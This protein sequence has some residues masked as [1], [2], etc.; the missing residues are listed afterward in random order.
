MKT[1]IYV[2]CR[3]GALR[4]C[5]CASRMVGLAKMGVGDLLVV[6]AMEAV[7]GS[8]AGIKELLAPRL[9]NRLLARMSPAITVVGDIELVWWLLIHPYD[10]R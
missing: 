6:E 3:R 10:G 9:A 1:V 2:C 8:H 5:S 4:T 7:R